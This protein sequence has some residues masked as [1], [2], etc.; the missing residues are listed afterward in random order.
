MCAHCC[1]VLNGSTVNMDQNVP[2]NNVFKE[3]TGNT[4][5][6]N[7][8]VVFSQTAAFLENWYNVNRKKQQINCIAYNDFDKETNPKPTPNQ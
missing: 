8:Y 2:T 4:S 7:W 3:F 1:L 5:Q 6:R